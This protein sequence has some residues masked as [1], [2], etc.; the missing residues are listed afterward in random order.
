MQYYSFPK[1]KIVRHRERCHRY[2]RER[3]SDNKV[4]FLV[5]DL[6]AR[7]TFHHRLSHGITLKN[8]KKETKERHAWYTLWHLRTRFKRSQ[9]LVRR[10]SDGDGFVKMR[11]RKAEGAGRGTN[12]HC[13]AYGQKVLFNDPL[14]V[15]HPQR[16]RVED[17]RKMGSSCFL[18]LPEVL[19]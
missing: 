9:R 13:I 17:P 1:V 15:G 7:Y 11:F 4:A 16:T 18:H 3:S 12:L 10:K 6:G 5:S 14:P 2:T 8:N 19:V